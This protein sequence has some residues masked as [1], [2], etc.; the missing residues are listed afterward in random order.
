MRR[1]QE[2]PLMRDPVGHFKELFHLFPY[3]VM[4][5]LFAGKNRKF[6]RL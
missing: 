4:M 3:G 6:G 5:F 2:G 1:K